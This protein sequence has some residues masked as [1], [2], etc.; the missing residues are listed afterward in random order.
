M[1]EQRRLATI[2]KVIF[3]K[4]VDIFSHATIEELGRV[5]ALTEEIH[6]EPGETIFREGEPTDAIYLILAGRVAVERSGQIVRE[7]TEK[8]AFGTVAAL[9]RNPAV[10][11]VKAMQPVYA[12]KLNAQ[13]FDDVLSV[14]FEL[15]RAV[16]HALC[17][18]IRQGQ[19]MPHRS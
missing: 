16:F 8:Q 6:F 14:D 1:M 3:L 9:D 5:A 19:S 18:L 15:V 4:S 17:Q 11:T 2:E 7:L 12:L 10:H 13:D